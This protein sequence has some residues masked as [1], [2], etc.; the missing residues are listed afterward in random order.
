MTRHGCVNVFWEQNM[1]TNHLATQEIE[2]DLGVYQVSLEILVFTISFNMI[3][4]E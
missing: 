4:L 2:R 3:Q 1:D